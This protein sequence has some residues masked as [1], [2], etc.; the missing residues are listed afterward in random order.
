MGGLR[1][2]TRTR[3]ARMVCH[4]KGADHPYAISWRLLWRALEA[5]PQ[6]VPL[7]DS[8]ASSTDS[9]SSMDLHVPTAPLAAEASIAAPADQAPAAQPRHAI[10]MPPAPAD[11]HE[12][13]DTAAGM[14]LLDRTLA[15]LAGGG[16][17][18][19]SVVEDMVAGLEQLRCGW[20]LVGRVRLGCLSAGHPV[21]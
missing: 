13:A 17:S 12:P 1:S 20:L 14:S 7:Q 8:V 4:A 2:G 10:F 11:Q 6:L 21:P 9:S 19:Y 5:A 18:S 3:L 16:E 15:R